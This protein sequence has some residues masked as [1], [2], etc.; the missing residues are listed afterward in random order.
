VPSK[1]EALGSIPSTIKKESHSLCVV[2]AFISGT[3]ITQPIPPQSKQGPQIWGSIPNT[4]QSVWIPHRAAPSISEGTVGM[5]NQG[6]I[7]V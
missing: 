2:G 7:P 3:V 5:H 1:C 4:G 6:V